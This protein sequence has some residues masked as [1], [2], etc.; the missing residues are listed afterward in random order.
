MKNERSLKKNKAELTDSTILIFFPINS[1]FCYDTV[2]GEK[3][4]VHALEKD[5]FSFSTH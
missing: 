4:N 3:V 5:L 2:Y 1:I